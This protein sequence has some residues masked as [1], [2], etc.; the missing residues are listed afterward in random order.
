MSNQFKVGCNFDFEL[1][2][3]VADLNEKYKGKA[4]VKEF[5]ASPSSAA[6][7]TARPDWRLPNI[8]DKDFEKYVQL[9]LDKG[10]LFNVVLNSIQPF[11]SK[12]SMVNHKEYIQNYVKWL[13][14]IGVYR[15]T[16]ANP[17][18]AMFIREVSNIELEASCILHIDTPTQMKYLHE[19]LGVNKFCNSILKNRSRD[20]LINCANYCNENNLILELLANEFCYNASADYATHCVYRDSCYLC[21]ATCKTKEESMMYNN[22]PMQY[23]M[24]SRNGNQEQWL[25]SRWIRPEDLKIYNT[26]GINYFKVSGRTG[27]TPYIVKVLESY[28]NEKYE[29][30]LL[31][32]WKPLETIY[33]G[34]EESEQ[35]LIDN[36]PNEKLDG[37]IN[38]WFDKNFECENQMCGTTCTYCR[39]FYNKKIKGEV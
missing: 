10:I 28:M 11:M 26:I 33:N 36:I 22:Y 17:M 24:S 34:K 15:I 18:M 38:H 30:N 2:N 1:I 19:T 12:P 8:S 16:F 20:F 9:S 23:C 5:F 14:N 3:K 31:G 6:P 39:D 13:E 35:E 7:M 21:H 37:F 25:R 4:E 29:G 32:L 27:G